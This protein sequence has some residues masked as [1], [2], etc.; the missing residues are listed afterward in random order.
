MI[1]QFITFL[2]HNPV[3]TFSAIV[4]LIL[5]ICHRISKEKDIV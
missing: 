4:L 1:Q 3:Y 2:A 5:F